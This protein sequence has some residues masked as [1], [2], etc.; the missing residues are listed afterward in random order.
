MIQQEFDFDRF[1]AHRRAIGA[2]ERD[3]ALDPLTATR[4]HLI[5]VATR[6]A[7][8]IARRRN[9]VTST[10]VLALM[11]RDPD[12]A[13]IMADVD[14][15]F[16]GAVFRPERGW[17]LIGYERTGSHARP[18]SVWALRETGGAAGQG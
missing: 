1:N 14:P 12:L 8:S 6:F 10:E 11:Q 15:R 18:V 17:Q 13:E 3:Q 2:M 16:M 4:R 7:V 9:R 5:D